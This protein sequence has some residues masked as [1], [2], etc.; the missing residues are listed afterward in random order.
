MTLSIGSLCTGYAGL[1]VAVQAVFGGEHAW[2]AENDPHASKVLAHHWRAVPNLGDV[3]LVD[4]TDVEPVDIVAAGFP[5]T[6]ISNTGD[7]EGI[8]GKDSRIWKNVAE[9]VRVLRPGLVV[10]ENVAAIRTRGLDRVAGDLAA[11]GYDTVWT[12]I[13]ASDAVGAA[14]E[15][16]RWFCLA[17]P[18][19]DSRRRHRWWSGDLSEAS[20]G[21]ES[22]YGG[23]P[24]TATGLRLLPTPKASDGPNGGPNQRDTAGNYYLPGL[25]VRLD[26]DWVSVDGVDYAPAI[27]RWEAITGRVAPE[28]TSF[29]ANGNA[30]LSA[31]FVEWLMGVPAGHVTAV[32]DIPRRHQIRILGGG[33]V[34]RHGI[35]GIELCLSMLAELERRAAA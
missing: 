4:W 1:D 9:S 14:H 26:E 10:L 34:P 15:R 3:T 19:A 8:D 27:H 29:L 5:C 16:Y 13:R 35:A 23:H 33:V 31:A 28:P 25:A 22:A 6:N 24:A 17:V 2:M 21:P 18:D 12:S 20:G 30:R 11:V 7:R 32:P